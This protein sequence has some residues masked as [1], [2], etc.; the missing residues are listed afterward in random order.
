M[1]ICK[2]CHY[3]NHGEYTVPATCSNKKAPISDMVTGDRYCHLINKGECDLY[4]PNQ[5][6]LIYGAVAALVCAVLVI[7]GIISYDGIVKSR[8]ATRNERAIAWEKKQKEPV[9]VFRGEMDG[10]EIILR[11]YR[12]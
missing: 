4:Q 7:G 1:N 9:K 6:F 10:K 2:N 12:K 3:Y 5:K 11:E 8:E